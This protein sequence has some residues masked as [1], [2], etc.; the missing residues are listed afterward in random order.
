MITGRSRT[1]RACF[2][3]T[4]RGLIGHLAGGSGSAQHIGEGVPQRMEAL[5]LP[6]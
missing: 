1:C 3:G 6:P 2:L 4:T 5:T